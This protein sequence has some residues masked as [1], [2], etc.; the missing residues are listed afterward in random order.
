MIDEAERKRERIEMR[1]QAEQTIIGSNAFKR[2]PESSP[3]YKV[4]DSKGKITENPE[5]KGKVRGHA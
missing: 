3:I 5:V 1:K 2:L 4:I